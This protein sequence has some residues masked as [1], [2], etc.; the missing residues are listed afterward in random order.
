[1]I[2]F[3]TVLLVMAISC[4]AVPLLLWYDFSHG[5]WFALSLDVCVAWMWVEF[6]WRKFKEANREW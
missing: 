2:K 1:M 4:V 6:I 5:Y 3:V